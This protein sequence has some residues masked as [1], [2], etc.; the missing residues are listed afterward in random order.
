MYVVAPVNQIFSGGLSECGMGTYQNEY[1]MLPTMHFFKQ[2]S[3]LSDA[4]FNDTSYSG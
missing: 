4:Q 1:F 3:F 2:I